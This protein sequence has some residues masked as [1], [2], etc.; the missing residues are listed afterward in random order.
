MVRSFR[1]PTGLAAVA[2]A[3]L[4]AAGCG[5]HATSGATG[6]S[7]APASTTVLLTV[8][9]DFDAAPWSQA[10]AQL[11]RIPG[12]KEFLADTLAGDGDLDFERDV[13]PAL[14]PETSVAI[15]DVSSDDDAFVLLTQPDDPAKFEQLAEDSGEPAATREVSGWW[16]MADSDATLDRFEEARKDG[17]LA[18]EDDY[19]AATKSLP[20]DAL[21][22]VYLSG[23][24]AAQAQGM[25]GAGADDKTL[26]CIFGSDDGV[27]SSAF[28]LTS[29][30][31]G[32]RLVGTSGGSPLAADASA[33]AEN[34]LPEQVPAGALAFVEGHELGDTLAR[35]IGCSAGKENAIVLALVE[36]ALGQPLEEAAKSLFGGETAILV[37]PPKRS[38]Q[39]DFESFALVT[40]VDDGQETLGLVDHVAE[41]AKTFEPGLT[42]A[43]TRGVDGWDLRIVHYED[44]DLTFAVKDDLLVVTPDPLL[45]GRFDGGDHLADSAAYKDT[46]AAAG[47]P[48]ETSGLAYVDVPA[49]AKLFGGEGPQAKALES[50]GGLVFWSEP[51]GDRVKSEGFLGID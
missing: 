18:D 5:D 44:T 23:A 50:L 37:Y 41:A 6:A 38:E 34:S 7:I 12:G 49:I 4:L 39:D 47:T 35:A 14:G 36:T 40:Q 46:L 30:A 1:L 42:V 16:A 29:E 43:T 8:D 26:A 28:A 45:V 11:E 24:A 10:Q 22:T 13:K 20:A 25:T 2:A 21:A 51:D 3:A 31:D 27:P 48:D 17:T 33:A 19:Q 32:L 15:L 9:T